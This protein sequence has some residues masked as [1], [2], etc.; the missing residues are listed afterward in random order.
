MS[1]NTLSSAQKSCY[2]ET[3]AWVVSV[4]LILDRLT[5]GALDHWTLNT[6]LPLFEFYLVMKKHPRYIRNP[7]MMKTALDQIC[8]RDLQGP[9]QRLMEKCEQTATPHARQKKE[10]LR[11]LQ[12]MCSLFEWHHAD[13]DMEE[14]IFSIK[15]H[16]AEDK[17]PLLPF[18]GSRLRRSADHARKDMDKSRLPR[19]MVTFIKRKKRAIAAERRFKVALG[20]EMLKR[21]AVTKSRVYNGS[22]LSLNG[23]DTEDPVKTVDLP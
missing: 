6:A 16:H 20:R 2:K 11:R 8:R 13:R 10:T 3:I 1:A 14:N 19:K 5:A 17:E 15:E 7:Y 12:D 21:L 18:L 23:K 4:H 22:F 9:L